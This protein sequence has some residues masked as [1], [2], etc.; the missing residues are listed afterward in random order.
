MASSRASRPGFRDEGRPLVA[1]R[2]GGA[3]GA[4]ALLG[5]HY[6]GLLLQLKGDCGAGRILSAHSERVRALPFEAGAVDIDDE[7]DWKSY[8]AA[9]GGS[10]GTAGKP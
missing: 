1:C 2:Y 4:P 9:R 3:L 6:K 5:G 10:D 7:S 8:L